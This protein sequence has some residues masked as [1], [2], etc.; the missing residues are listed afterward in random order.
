[1][2]DERE[3]HFELRKDLAS[4][5]S[6][7]YPCYPERSSLDP[8]LSVVDDY[9]NERLAEQRARIIRGIG[10]DEQKC[11]AVLND[12]PTDRHLNGRLLA[13]GRARDIVEEEGRREAI[14]EAV[15]RVRAGG[16]S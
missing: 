7:A 16:E 3:R 5:L 8:V 13:L 14:E 11:I 12:R 9:V 15:D 2:T 4:A 10:S 1:M 6:T